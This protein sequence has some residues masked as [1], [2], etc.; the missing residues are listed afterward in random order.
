MRGSTV[1][2]DWQSNF[3]YA[4]CSEAEAEDRRIPG[5]VHQ[6]F[7]RYV[8]S[9]IPAIDAEMQRVQP[10]KVSL[11]GDS[12][13]GAVAN[14]MATY[15]ARGYGEM[16]TEKV[17]GCVVGR[18]W[19]AAAAPWV[20]A[21]PSSSGCDGQGSVHCCAVGDGGAWRV[22]SSTDSPCVYCNDFISHDARSRR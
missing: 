19:V 22:P 11:A 12:L 9:L 6:G 21:V 13:G 18:W 4:F 16:L 2:D 14:L 17:G 10:S 5:R 7:L 20:A 1:D 8:E 3:A 15:I